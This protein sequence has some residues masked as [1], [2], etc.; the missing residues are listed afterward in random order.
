MTEHGT[1]TF[2]TDAVIFTA[3]GVQTI[4]GTLTLTTDGIAF[5]ATGDVVAGTSGTLA[6]ITGDASFSATCQVAISGYSAFQ[7]DSVQA[8]GL[9]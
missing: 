7:T 6:F 9:A 3:S 2:A 4:S 8:V 5:D 1:L